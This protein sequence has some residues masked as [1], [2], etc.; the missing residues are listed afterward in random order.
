VVQA[1]SEEKPN[2]AKVPLK[3][4]KM[5]EIKKEEIV[6]EIK[7]KILTKPQPQPA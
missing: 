7:V 2:Q 5:K 3:E 1:F 6:E 4:E